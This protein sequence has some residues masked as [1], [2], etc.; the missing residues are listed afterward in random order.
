MP[1]SEGWG[2]VS[3]SARSAFSAARV[4]RKSGDATPTKSPSRTTV[5]PGIA[6]AVERSTL[7]SL[8]PYWGAKSTRP[9]NMPAGGVSGP[10]PP[11]GLAQ[12]CRGGDRLRAV[13]T[14]DE[15]ANPDR[16]S[17]RPCSGTDPAVSDREIGL[18]DPEGRRGDLQNDL[19][20]G[21][22]RRSEVLP[23]VGH[24]PA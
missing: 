16:A 14:S 22:R 6:A 8:A 7:R 1:P 11:G 20:R 21:G 23:G 13:E 24:R 5:T 9:C 3:H 18:R 2:V 19:P 12:L 17:A 10:R 15:V 4:V